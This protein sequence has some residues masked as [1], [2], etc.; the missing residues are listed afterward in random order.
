M[1]FRNYRLRKKWL[2]KRLKSYISEDPSTRDM[3]NG[4]KNC[5]N[6]KASTFTTFIDHCED[7]TLR[8]FVNTLTANDKYYFLNCD[9]LTEPIQMQLS[10]KQKKKSA[11][12]SQIFESRLNAVEICSAVLYHIYWSMLKKLSWKKDHLLTQWLPMT[13]IPFLTVTN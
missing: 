4:A 2:D 7:K 6:L 13:S 3:V 9:I 1:Y 10:K 8:L 5:W 11:L 12:F